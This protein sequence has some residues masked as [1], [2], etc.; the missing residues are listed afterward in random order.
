MKKKES[1]FSWNGNKV[2]W[3]I[4]I[5]T[6]TLG[7]IFLVYK[8]DDRYAKCEEVKEKL[9]QQ[10]KGVVT[11]LKAFQYELQKSQES[12]QK[13]IDLKYLNDRKTTLLDQRR[14]LKINLRAKPNDIDLQEQLIEVNREIDKVDKQ[15][16]E[17]D[18]K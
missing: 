3:W 12:Y 8:F 13:K 17:L 10:E 2:K 4:G 14:Q 6:A 9:A 7:A 16:T 18:K 15:I 11:T 1:R 5:I